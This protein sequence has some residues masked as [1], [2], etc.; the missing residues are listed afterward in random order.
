MADDYDGY[1]TV[2]MAK[3]SV[4]DALR[5][6]KVMGMPDPDMVMEFEDMACKLMKKEKRGQ[7][8]KIRHKCIVAHF[9][10]PPIL[11]VGA[12]E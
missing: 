7:S 6:K 9:G 1:L 3:L 8:E 10:V 12:F 4:K 5:K 11:S 2:M